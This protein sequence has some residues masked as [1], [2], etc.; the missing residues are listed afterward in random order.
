MNGRGLACASL[1]ALVPGCAVVTGPLGASQGVPFTATAVDL[2]ILSGACHF[3]GTAKVFGA[4]DLPFA[5]AVDTAL[6]PVALALHVPELFERRPPSPPPA[7]PSEPAP[8]VSGWVE[9]FHALDLAHHPA[10]R[11]AVGELQDVRLGDDYDVPQRGVLHLLGSEGES[12]VWITR[13]YAT[14]DAWERHGIRAVEHDGAVLSAVLW[15]DDALPLDL[16]QG[17]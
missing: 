10:V 1:V 8:H 9:A 12:M 13:W 15:T 17:R 4:V 6:L 7:P 14:Q 11:D 16:L 3:G 2:G 5:L